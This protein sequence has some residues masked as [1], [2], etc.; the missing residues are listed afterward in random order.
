MIDGDELAH[1]Q[2]DR[3]HLK[4]VNAL[5]A[6][7]PGELSVQLATRHVNGIPRHAGYLW[8][9]AFNVCFRVTYDN[10]SAVVRFTSNG[11]V[12]FLKEKLRD[13]VEIMRYLAENTSV[14]VPMV[15]GFGQCERAPY[16]VMAFVP[17]DTLK[18]LIQDPQ[19]KEL[20]LNPQL[21]PADLRKAYQAM[22]NILLELSKPEFPVIGAV[23]RDSAGTW[24]VSKRPLSFNMNNL[25][26]YSNIPPQSFVQ[27]TFATAADYFEELANQHFRHLQFQRNDAV[28]DEADCTKKYVARCLF[29]SASRTISQEHC[30]GPF[31]LFCDDLSPSNLLVDPQ[32]YS[33]NGVVDWEWTYVAPAEF[34]YAAP[35]WLLLQRPES[36]DADLRH[37][38][39]RYNRVLP[40]FLDALQECED[41]KIREGTLLESQRLSKAMAESMENGMFWTCL[42]ARFGCL[43]D[44]IYWT[45]LDEKCFGPFTTIE[46]RISLLSE[47]E[48]ANLDGFVKEKLIQAQE[49]TL[50]S[51]LTAEE[52]KEL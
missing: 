50:V 21:D 9:G 5:L 10:M 26:R 30:N 16:I 13:E 32:T 3:I 19:S 2:A 52:M 51:H 18:D 29:R 48:R 4:W 42:A 43:L 17:G 33:V 31:K 44:D 45:F 40:V 38:V 20:A 14:P 37:F 41:A 15:F 25:A 12:I 28:K 22:A 6:S 49:K 7:K 39:P 23:S 46:D 24:T 47:E 34:T 8:N 35:W 36:W 11:R 1:A 27:R